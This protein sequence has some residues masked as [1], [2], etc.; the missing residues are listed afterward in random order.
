MTNFTARTEHRTRYGIACELFAEFVWL[1]REAGV[2]WDFV[3]RPFSPSVTPRIM[4]DVDV[5][6][7]SVVEVSV[8]TIYFDDDVIRVAEFT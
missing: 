7:G 8:A 6:V 3:S 1:M 2:A 4:V 5:H